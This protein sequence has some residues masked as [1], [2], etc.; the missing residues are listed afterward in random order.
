[1]FDYMATFGKFGSPHTRIYPTPRV[2]PVPVFNVSEWDGVRV[3]HQTAHAF[4]IRNANMRMWERVLGSFT[5]TK[6]R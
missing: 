5:E 1:M 2:S 3:R 4:N 6:F